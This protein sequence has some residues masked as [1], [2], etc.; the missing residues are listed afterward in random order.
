MPKVNEQ[1]LV[2]VLT[3]VYNGEAYLR[4]CIESVLE[5]TYQNWEYLIVNNCSTDGTLE[6]AQEYA[7]RDPRIHVH[8]NE[9]FLPI[10]QNINNTFRRLSRNS[11]YCKMVLADDWIFPDCLEKMVAVA[12]ANSS[13]GIVGA[14]GLN[15]HRVVWTGLPYPSFVVDGRAISHDTLT[16]GPYIFGSPTTV[17]CRSDL[18]RSKDPFLDESN[19]HGDYHTCLT[20]LQHCDFGF[21]HQVLTCTRKREDSATSLS[22]RYNTYLLENLTALLKFGPIYL[23]PAECDQQMKLWRREYHTYLG[24]SVLCFREKEFWNHHRKRLSELGHPL[25]W[26]RVAQGLL[27]AFP[28]ALY[29]PIHSLKILNGAWSRAWQRVLRKTR[30]RG[31]A[32]AS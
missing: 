9:K 28:E 6:I 7:R 1:P 13:V 3:P 18:V 24:Q 23:T 17:C 19:P 14:Y 32:R 29:H 21:V 8:D 31:A 11:K 26:L 4:Q 25:S 20:L 5:Q 22:L 2:M 27:M 30:Q 12:E 15:G 16:G 10:M